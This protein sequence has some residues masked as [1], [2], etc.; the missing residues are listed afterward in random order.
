V[1]AVVA[2]YVKNETVHVTPLVRIGIGG[3]V[4]LPGFHYVR[5]D[6]PLGDLMTRAGGLDQNADATNIVINRGSAT[7]WSKTDVAS[8]M[9]DGLTLDRLGLEPG[10][11]VV[12]GARS[13]TSKWMV[14]LQYG[15]PI[16]TAVMIPILLQR[17]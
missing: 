3:A 5:R 15:L 2:K 12:V 9:V 1:T 7:I 17:R 4:R 11:Q 8:A 6:M 16:L 14:F 10:D 13:T